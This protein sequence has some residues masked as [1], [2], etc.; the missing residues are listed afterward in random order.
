MRKSAGILLYRKR[1]ALEVFLVHP[2]GPYWKGKEEGAWGIPKGEFEETE[3]P[4]EAARREFR[5][6]TGSA[7]EGPAIELVPVRQKAGKLVFAWAVEGDLD[8]AAF[9]SNTFRQEYPYK[10]GKWITVPEVDKAGWFS[11]IE[12]R[13]LMNPAQ[14]PLL[15]D[16]LQKLAA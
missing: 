14:V 15:D 7:A 2:G 8:A 3:A 11:I 16:L 12:A 13:K 1:G 4:L 5:E 10:S 6:E 9:V